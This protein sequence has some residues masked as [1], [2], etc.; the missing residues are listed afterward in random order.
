MY[1][2]THSQKALLHS[3]NILNIQIY[4]RTLRK[5]KLVVVERS[6]VFTHGSL[7]IANIIARL[8]PTALLHSREDR[9]EGYN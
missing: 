7:E 6:E 5:Q 9:Y 1:I 2:L 4:V 8:D 3:R